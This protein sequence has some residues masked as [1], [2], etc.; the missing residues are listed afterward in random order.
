MSET[1]AAHLRRVVEAVQALAGR[2]ATTLAAG[3]PS[4]GPGDCDHVVGYH[5]GWQDALDAIRAALAPVSSSGEAEGGERRMVAADGITPGGMPVCSVC[6]RWSCDCPAPVPSEGQVDGEG[7]RLSADEIESLDLRFEAGG[8][9][10]LFPEVERILTARLA[11]RPVLS[12]EALA[13]ELRAMRPSTDANRLGL[14]TKHRENE[15]G[16]VA[17]RR[18]INDVLDR[19]DI[20]AGG[21]PYDPG[22]KVCGR[23]NRNGTHDALERTGHLSHTFIPV[24]AVPEGGK[25][26][27]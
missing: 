3:C 26:R 27:G 11:A 5:E 21:E 20:L 14:S 12:R 16:R 1:E 9:E 18:A 22:C 2:I 7:A 10:A 19:L 17:Y 13:D 23:D 8:I 6:G 4:C 15:I 24:P 25:P